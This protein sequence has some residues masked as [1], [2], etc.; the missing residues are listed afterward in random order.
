MTIDSVSFGSQATNLSYG[1]FP[2][3]T[4]SYGPMSPTYSA[5]NS[6]FL[7]LDTVQVGDLV[8]NEFMADNVST[9]ADP[10]GEFDDWIEL[11]NNTANPI[12]LQY[13]FLTDDKNDPTKWAFPD[14][15]IAANDF[16]M[17][18][19]DNDTFQAGLHA[20][21]GLGASGDFLW[22]G[23]ADGT[24]IDSISF[25]TQQP[26]ISTGR[27]PNG[28][29]AFQ[30]MPP[31]FSFP[32]SGFAPLDTISSGELVLNEAA[33]FN[34]LIQDSTGE[35]DDWIELYNNTSAPLSL[36]GVFLSD[37]AQ[38][39]AQWGF[40]DTTIAANGYLI[41]W[42]DGQTTQAGLHTNFSLSSTFGET[43][44]LGYSDGTPIDQMSFG[45]Q[46]PDT[47]TGRFPNG[48]GPFGVML[49]TFAAQNSSFIDIDTIQNG[50]IV[51][52]EI[53]A[54][55]T[56][57][58]TDQDLEFDDWIEL[59]NNTPNPISLSKVFLSDDPQNPAL[60]PFPDTIIEAN[61]YLIIWADNDGGQ[62]GLHADFALASA[63]ETLFL[64]YADGKVIDEL[65]Y[66][67]IGNDTT[68]GRAPNGTGPFGYMNPTFSSTNSGLIT[69]IDAAEGNISLQIYPNPLG[70]ER[71][72]TIAA[73]EPLQLEIRLFNQMGQEIKRE[74]MAGRQEIFWDLSA[75]SPGLYY[76]QLGRQSWEK[77]ILE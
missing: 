25:Q 23:Y 20:F 45:P 52:N 6:P 36:R 39:L 68:F 62:A 55:N 42:A 60:W 46:F 15:S 5:N 9:Q 59:Y 49:P 16:L 21:F 47:T 10:T 54:D 43:L 51:I 30:L 27:L 17:V 65:S 1:R 57:T 26:D 24:V 50:E 18:W 56:V 66:W 76:L 74:N 33:A 31:T 72:L 28:T 22:L 41:V 71:A 19:A 3:G 70:Q 73:N 38:D 32:N 14:T 48:T 53:M 4:G 12:S 69:S 64:G 11:Y 7:I 58:I 29:G 63:G 75:F 8:I 40:P 61:S 34:T 67:P 35:F 44:Y 77:L 13:L 2:N 37:D